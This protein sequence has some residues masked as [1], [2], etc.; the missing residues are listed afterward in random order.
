MES[1]INFVVRLIDRIQDGI[2]VA[3]QNMREV[4]DII[5]HR[6]KELSTIAWTTDN[7][8]TVKLEFSFIR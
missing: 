5:M 1:D 4:A 6:L 8:K 3:E 7:G 2:E